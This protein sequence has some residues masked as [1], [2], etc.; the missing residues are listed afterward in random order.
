MVIQYLQYPTHMVKINIGN[1][2][3]HDSP[4]TPMD[5]IRDMPFIP[6]LRIRR[7]CDKARQTYTSEKDAPTRQGDEPCGD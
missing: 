5:G 3:E 2:G 1:S 6:I 7:A 4:V